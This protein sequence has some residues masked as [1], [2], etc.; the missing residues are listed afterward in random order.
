VE[1][2][3][4]SDTDGLSAS[5][6]PPIAREPHSARFVSVLPD[7]GALGAISNNEDINKANI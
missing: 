6:G 1:C 3:T 2:E 4:A 7:A 5:K